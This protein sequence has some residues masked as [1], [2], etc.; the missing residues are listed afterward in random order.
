MYKLIFSLHLIL[1]VV[2]MFVPRFHLND[3]TIRVY[4]PAL[5]LELHSKQI[6]AG[7][8]IAEDSFKS[9]H[10]ISSTDSNVRVANYLI[11]LS[12]GVKW[13]RF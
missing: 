11:T 13:L 2:Y 6:A 10:R 9:H 8:S 7:E 5:K 12:L 1:C 4:P 3:H